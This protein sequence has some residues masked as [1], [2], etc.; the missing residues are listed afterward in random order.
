MFVLCG[1]H[2]RSTAPTLWHPILSGTTHQPTDSMAFLCSWLLHA[3]LGF[4]PLNI[5]EQQGME[6]MMII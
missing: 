1:I 2:G 6:R 5:T 4:F 3:L